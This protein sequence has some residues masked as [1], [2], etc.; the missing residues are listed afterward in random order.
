MPVSVGKVLG[1]GVFA[2]EGALYDAQAGAPP[3]SW[4]LDDA[5]RLPGA[6]N[7]QNA[8]LAFAAAK[9]FV[10]DPR[11]IA[12]AIAS[13]P[14][15]AH[16]M[17]DVGRIGKTRFVNDS[18]ATNADAAAR[19]LACL[20]RYFLD[21]RRQGPRPA[22]SKAS[23]RISPAPQGLSDR[24][25]GARLRPHAG[26]P[27]AHEMAGHAGGGGGHVRP[28]TPRLRPRRRRSCCCRRPAPPS[29]SSAISSSAATP[30]APPWRG[31]RSDV[32]EAHEHLA[33]RQRRLRHLVVHGGQGGAHRHGAA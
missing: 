16:R 32:R 5:P 8:A 27:R 15:L 22:A 12:A 2:V 4:T 19:A 30:S 24:R 1:R 21:R 26:R 3:R 33:R 17:E 29:T 31:C 23:C 13:F 18:K 10:K 28:P 20:S 25:G 11:V 9:P 7:W 14:G 6:H